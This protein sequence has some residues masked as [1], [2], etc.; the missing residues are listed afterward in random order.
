MDVVVPCLVAQLPRPRT[1]RLR[2]LRGLV[3]GREPLLPL[4]QLV[5]PSPSPRPRPRPLSPA[6]AAAKD[7]AVRALC[8]VVTGAFSRVG[9]K[10]SLAA[11]G[12][13]RGG[14]PRVLTA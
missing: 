2:D 8:S 5:P 11:H 4:L 14:P 6:Q 1:Q 7:D 9:M 12:R 3:F 10:A 13:G